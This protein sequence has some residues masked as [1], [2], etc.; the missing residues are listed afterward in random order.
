MKYKQHYSG[1][2]MFEHEDGSWNA[3]INGS[4]RRV[5][6]TFTSKGQTQ[7]GITGTDDFKLKSVK[8]HA[9]FIMLNMAGITKEAKYKKPGQ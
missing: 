8:D 9:K 6:R 1:A 2:F 7:H 5:G 4:W 3:F